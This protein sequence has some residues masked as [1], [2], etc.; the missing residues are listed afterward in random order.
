[1]GSVQKRRQRIADGAL[2]KVTWRVRYRDAN[3]RQ[4]SHSFAR[5]F[6]AERFLERN[7]SDIQRGEWVDPILRRSSFADW[8][9][10]WWGT[11]GKLRPN[12]RRGYWLLLKNHVLPYF[13]AWRLG[14]IDYL[15][16]E[17]FITEKLA[18]GHGRKQVRQMVSVLSLIMKCAVKANARKDNPAAGHELRAPHGRAVE[19]PMLTM[20]QAAS[21]VEH[22]SSH[23]KAAMWLL[24]FTGM[25]PA[26]LCGLRVQ[27]VDL[28]RRIVHIRRTWSPVPGF[29]GGV[30]STSLVR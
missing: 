11:T 18:S 14:A 6:D 8:A 29:D 23:Y 28:V 1:M 30:G 5:R 15:E 26:E 13:G 17:R 2:G 21:L 20:E 22:A 10:A 27:D 25:R 24:I 9:D 16:V 19:V 4:R 7:G 3:G 12:T